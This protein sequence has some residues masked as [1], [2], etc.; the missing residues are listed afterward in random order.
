[1]T[2]STAMAAFNGLT[3]SRASGGLTPVPNS[4]PT[5]PSTAAATA[6]RH[7]VAPSR[8]DCLAALF[9]HCPCAMA[10]SPSRPRRCTCS[11][12]TFAAATLS[13]GST[14]TYPGPKSKEPNAASI[15]DAL[16]HIHGVS[17]KVLSLALVVLLLGGRPGDSLWQAAGAQLIVID[18]LVHNWLHRTGILNGLDARHRYGPKCYPSAFP[19]LIQSA[20][21]RFCAADAFDIAMAIAS[22][23]GSHAQEMAVRSW[24]IAA[25]WRCELAAWGAPSDS[26]FVVETQRQ[27]LIV[28]IKAANERDDPIVKAKTRAA[29]KSRRR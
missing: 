8:C 16:R 13:V 20:I 29:T 3:L 18:T 6:N 4:R 28:E 2:I 9:R 27:K 19:R 21:W 14:T 17:D 11:C 12:A 24:V 10:A 22:T 25:V 7:A 5:G 15:V 23:T 1:V 26:Y